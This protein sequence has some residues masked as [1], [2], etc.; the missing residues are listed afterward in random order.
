MAEL[1][2]F[3]LDIVDEDIDKKNKVEKRIKDLSDKVRLTSEE[4]D[5]KEKL[6]RE[7][8]AELDRTVK[9]RDFYSSFTD[10]TVKYPGANEYKDTIKD[11]V[12]LG[13]SVEDAT[14]A[15]LAS[16]G[17]L[18]MPEPAAEPE[19]NPAGGSAV[20]QPPTGEKKLEEMT[21]AEKRE[22]V[23]EAERKGEI[24]T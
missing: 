5:E 7:R 21:L 24:T 22:A 13:Y 18:V 16:E 20:N 6:L 23:V 10:A 19:P 15:V 3:D 2:E 8:D 12:L 9:E 14:V 1:D 11:K 4:R 17:K